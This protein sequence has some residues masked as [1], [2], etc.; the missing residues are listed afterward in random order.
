M[1]ERTGK[2]IKTE[3]KEE[4]RKNR[5]KKEKMEEKRQKK[6]SRPQSGTLCE[7]S[8]LEWNSNSAS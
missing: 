2:G 4:F 7:C 5:D 1:E 8:E 6:R 3:Q